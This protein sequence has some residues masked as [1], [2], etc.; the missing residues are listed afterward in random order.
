[1]EKLLF[2]EI[3]LWGN[4]KRGGDPITQAGAREGAYENLEK[5]REAYRNGKYGSAKDSMESM[6]TKF[7]STKEKIGNY[8]RFTDISIETGHELQEVKNYKRELDITTGL[9]TVSYDLGDSSFKREYFCSHPHDAT[10]IRYTSTNDP[11]TLSLKINMPHK[12]SS[13]EFKD[14]T[15]FVQAAVSMT[16]DDVEFLHA[17]YI[18]AKEGK[19]S[20]DKD[21]VV[22]IS[23]SKDVKIY[24]T[25]YTDYL[26][27]FPSFKGRD[28]V[29]DV[30]KNIAVLKETGYEK[31]KEAHVA[32]VSELMARCSFHLDF[33]PSGKT[34]DRMI[35]DK[36]GAELEVL[37]FQYARYMQI[38]CSR[39]APV[40]SN[41][42]GIWNA[43]SK[44][45]W[46]CDYHT[47]INLAMNYWMP[48]PSNLSECFRPYA[49]YMKVIAESGKINAKETFGVDKGWSMGLN[50]NVYGFTAQNEHGRRHQQAG[51]WLCQNLYEHY[52]FNQDRAYL[53]EIY[54]IMKGAAEF[55]A[56]YLA[57]I[58]DGTLAIYPTWSPECHYNPRDS[59][60]SGKM[61]LNKQCFGAAW[62]QQ[63]IVNLFT[64]MIEATLI[65]DQDSELR[66][67]LREL[68]P[69]LSP[70]KI[71]QYGQVQEWPEDWDDPKNTHRHISHL[72]ALH[73]GRDIS[74]LSTPELYDAALVTMKHRGDEATGWSVGWK[75][76]FWAR[77]HNG[78]RVHDIYK[79]LLAKKVHPN[80]FDFHPPFQID[81]NFGAA[82]GICEA[83]LQSHL[84][85]IN[86]DAETIQEAAYVAYE[87]KKDNEKEFL[88][89]V[90]PDSLVDAPFILHL[91]PALPSE[92]EN[93]K[94]SGLKA[95]GGFLVDLEW[96]GGELKS[97]KI[98]ATK[99]GAFRLF[100][101]KKLSAD[102]ALKAG[103]SYSFP[104]S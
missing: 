64:D 93:G 25:A 34:T 2:N 26:P 4:T 88:A 58:G 14:N 19:V 28:F 94:I 70:Q 46:N 101:D 63:L 55:F 97:A 89:V 100:H 56:E 76:C 85:S 1:M 81:G 52:S 30:T 29:T 12:A 53:E 20:A 49:E 7:L 5:V 71:G 96:A 18:D 31:L 61:K 11:Q 48:D 43:D 69:K 44:P 22:S 79:R 13:V 16:Q 65:L 50:G 67:K 99:D 40:P 47:D 66:A 74:P 68:L 87:P 51:H 90:P 57:P 82:A 35:K 15:L 21:G 45:M 62:D 78:D 32:D 8:A 92:W 38:A 86:S 33:E 42:Q 80:L 36:V 24:T 60:K 77:L 39:S 54:P 9:G 75:T 83:L 95:R 10:M 59:K 84:R 73:P 6:S 23:G 104:Q 98:T 72:I 27:K 17:V 91:L 102:I 103:E 41:L 37:H 3:T